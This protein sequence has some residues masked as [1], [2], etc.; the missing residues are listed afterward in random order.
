MSKAL[1]E[2][3][4]FE[5]EFDLFVL[6]EESD[7]IEY[8]FDLEV[9]GPRGAMLKQV[10]KFQE[11]QED[12]FRL[13]HVEDIIVG[14]YRIC[15]TKYDNVMT[16]NCDSLSIMNKFISRIIDHGHILVRDKNIEKTNIDTY[17]YFKAYVV[18]KLGMPI[19][20]N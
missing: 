17:K 11:R 15:I 7:K 4:I 2:I 6:L 10:A 18:H 16:F 5:D 14:N 20:A 13:A 3:Q 9:L 19:C 8:L 1:D 12:E